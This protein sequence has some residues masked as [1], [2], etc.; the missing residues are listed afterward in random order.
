VSPDREPSAA[1]ARPGPPPTPPAP[2]PDL[3][4]DPARARAFAERALDLWTEYLER[5]PDLPVAHDAGEDEVRAAVALPVPEEPMPED[6]LAAYL[7]D[8]V[9]RWSMSPGHPRYMA[10]ISG[11]GT[12]PGVAAD[13]LAAGLNQNAGAWRL[14]PAASEIELNLTRWF[15]RQFGLPEGAGGLIV[16]G[17][18]MAAFVGLKV[19]RDRQAGLGVRQQGVAGAGR[20]AIYGSSEVHVVTDRAADMLGVGMDA[21]RRVAV[22]AGRRMDVAALDEAVARDRAAGVTPIA[23]VA[24]AGTIE[25]GA[26]DP[27]PEIADLC[28]REGLWLHV[29]AS[30]GG[31]AVLADDLRPLLAGIERAH[32]IAFDPHK[33]LYTP[34]SGGCVLVRDLF[35]LV[36]SFG[37]V[38]A[39]VH[40]DKERTRHGMDLGMFGPQFSR[41]FQSLKIWL[42][43]LA[44]GRRAY[45][46]RISHDA[47]LARYLGELVATREDF[48]LAC[49]V[50]LSIACFRY[51]PADLPAAP[52]GERERYLNRLNERI[53]TEVQLDGRV[54]YSN[55]VLDGR[56]VLR[57]CLVN[58]RT[59]ARDV[60]AVVAVTAEIG[61]KLDR[62]LRPG[63]MR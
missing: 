18:A 59:E 31:P 43:L 29:D 22:D 7:R 62:E 14:S 32:S 11:P 1:S 6:E 56:F 50:G 2:V 57:A 41:S 37:V 54:F 12:A 47:A 52:E 24:T 53:M 27:L 9:F 34:H 15:A 19:A 28:E 39:Y 51:M 45:G 33:W 48:E 20:V 58:F 46:A 36:D 55:A 61:A 42:S 35:W 30:Y 49:P 10:Y 17:G 3:D 38:P 40:E 4:W 44:H 26:I 63:G 21:V 60:E 8:L 25:T 23:V 16:S 13:L 5:L